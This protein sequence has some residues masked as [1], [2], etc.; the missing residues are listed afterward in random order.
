MYVGMHS[1]KNNI[2]TYCGSPGAL[3]LVE[4]LTHCWCWLSIFL[5]LPSK[6]TTSPD[7]VMHSLEIN[8]CLMILSFKARGLMAS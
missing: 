6:L 2:S 4:R 1:P 5:I 8:T 7:S 3:A